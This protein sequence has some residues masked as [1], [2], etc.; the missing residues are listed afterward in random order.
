MFDAKQEI[1]KVRAEVLLQKRAKYKRSKLD[2]YNG[3]VI[4]LKGGGATLREIS[5]YL[6]SKGL[7]SAPSTIARYLSRIV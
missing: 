7:N 5:H 1:D 4:A 6:K 2:K 3:E